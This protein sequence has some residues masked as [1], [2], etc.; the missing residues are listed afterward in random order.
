MN[1]TVVS[2]TQVS[3]PKPI[4]KRQQSQL[5]P[6]AEIEE[7][8]KVERTAKRPDLRPTTPRRYV[9]FSLPSNDQAQV[10]QDFELD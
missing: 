1:E 4:L 7:I 10:L 8:N 9:E 3:P 6:D 2:P 5:T